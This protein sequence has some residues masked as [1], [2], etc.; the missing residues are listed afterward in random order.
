MRRIDVSNGEV[1]AYV[2]V[3]ATLAH[4]HFIEASLI[5]RYPTPHHMVKGISGEVKE[6]SAA[7]EA[8]DQRDAHPLDYTAFS[9]LL[10][11]HGGG[12]DRSKRQYEDRIHNTTPDELADIVLRALTL[13][14]HLGYD[15]GTAVAAK[16]RYNE[17][18]P[19]HHGKG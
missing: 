19:K 8:R 16:L 11:E 9:L 15:M 18:R 14:E 2:R 3:A 7:L 6:L 10:K 1:A 4:D 13:G 17:M 12:R 5:D